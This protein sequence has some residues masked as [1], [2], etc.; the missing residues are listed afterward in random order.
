MRSI[1]G[2]TMSHHLTRA[3]VGLPCGACQHLPCTYHA[4]SAALRRGAEGSRAQ[5]HM[6][7]QDSRM[8]VYTTSSLLNFTF[9]HCTFRQACF[10]RSSP[11][12]L[13]LPSPPS[14]GPAMPS[15]QAAPSCPA[16]TAYLTTAYHTSA[17]TSATPSK[18]QDEEATTLQGV[19]G[20]MPSPATRLG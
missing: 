17:D 5:L 6:T 20:G 10:F 3:R 16:R 14:S 9:S 13:P 2:I 15:G 12:L 7:F 19:D 8:T 18:A 4:V 1:S 11:M